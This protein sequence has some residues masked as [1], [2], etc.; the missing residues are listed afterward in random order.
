MVTLFLD[1]AGLTYEKIYAE[2][3]EQFFIDHGIKEAPTLIVVKKDGY[4][5]VANP[6]NIRKF[7]DGITQ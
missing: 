5:A 2:D 3:N 6:S 4:E 7:I 1:R